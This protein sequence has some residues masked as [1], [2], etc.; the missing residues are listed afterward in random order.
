[1]ATSTA[2]APKM[3]PTIEPISD[4]SLRFWPLLDAL[5]VL[6]ALGAVD[7]VV[8]GPSGMAAAWRR[9][10]REIVKKRR[11][12]RE[13]SMGGLMLMSFE[14]VLSLEILVKGAQEYLFKRTERRKKDTREVAFDMMLV[15]ALT[16]QGLY[17][18]CG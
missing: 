11:V 18:V 13:E 17:D 2:N 5:L 4:A 3:A 7:G 6:A 12:G 14:G 9:L 1:M 8:V 10:R 15:S 16:L